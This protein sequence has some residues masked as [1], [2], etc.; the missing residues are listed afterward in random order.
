MR[1]EDGPR[2]IIIEVSGDGKDIVLRKDETASLFERSAVLST[3]IQMPGMKIIPLAN[4]RPMTEALKPEESKDNQSN[5][6]E[7]DNNNSKRGGGNSNKNKRGK[8]PKQ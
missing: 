1:T 5:K 8:N 4:E 6:K 7:D 3:V 2:Q